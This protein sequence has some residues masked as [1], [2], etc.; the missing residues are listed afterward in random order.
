MA[1]SFPEFRK[2]ERARPG[3]QYAGPADVCSGLLTSRYLLV[4][5][6]LLFFAGGVVT[7]I[8]LLPLH[9]LSS[10]PACEETSLC[11]RRESTRRRRS[12][13]PDRQ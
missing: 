1:E 7:D 2:A 10:M 9:T 12:Y 11:A 13:V 5:L 3:L 6:V 8:L 4:P